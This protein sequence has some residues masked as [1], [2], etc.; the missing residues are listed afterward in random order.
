MIETKRCPLLAVGLLTLLGGI[1]MTASIEQR[2]GPAPA[3]DSA[4]AMVAPV[5]PQ[6]SGYAYQRSI[7]I[8]HT[9]VPNTNQ[10]NFPVLVSGTYSYL[11]TV[12][13]GGNVQN[14]NGYDV[15]F[16]SD[17]ACTTKLDH[18]VETY[19]AATGAVNYWVRVP[20]LSHT[21]DTT[22]YL[23]YGNS[24]ITTDQSNKTGV[25]DSNFKA[26]YHLDDQA[27]NTS[28]K[29]SSANL[30]NGTNAANTSGKTITGKFAQGLTYNGTSDNTAT[31]VA[32]TGSFTWECWF[33][34]TDWTTQSGSSD[35]STLM[36]G[37]YASGGALLMLWKDSAYVVQFAAD[38][39]GGVTSG[40]NSV[41]PGAW[42]EFVESSLAPAP[43]FYFRRIPQRRL[44]S[45]SCSK[46]A[47]D[48][49]NRAPYLLPGT[50]GKEMADILDDEDNLRRISKLTV[51]A[52]E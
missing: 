1:A 16:T 26:V 7:T 23:C 50:R 5:P 40:N 25:W 44:P 30:S 39:A 9:K 14:A 29:D 38:N 3:R 6:Q 21:A 15:I 35:Y 32:Q 43:L 11:A 2:N 52:R 10:T 24:G 19:S 8:D 47:D 13:N 42:H 28:I 48:L 18:E 17:A 36:A 45:S 41:A 4:M 34:L 20:S 12:S 33:K 22:I 49:E 51:T 31:G 27:A 46:V 37:T